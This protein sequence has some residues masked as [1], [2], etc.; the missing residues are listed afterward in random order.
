MKTM[1]NTNFLS[2][3]LLLILSISIIGSC[4]K[5]KEEPGEISVYTS[6]NL[7]VGNIEIF[8]NAEYKGSIANYAYVAST[9]ECGSSVCVNATVPDG[10]FTL[11]AVAD[12]GSEWV[13]SL[14]VS[15]G[16]CQ[17]INL[18]LGSRTK[19]PPP[20]TNNGQ[21][22]FWETNATG[23]PS[24]TDVTINGITNKVT[25]FSVSTPACGSS[26]NA[27]FSLPPGSYNYTASCSGVTKTGTV[28]VTAGQCTPVQ[29]NWTTPPPD[30][31]GQVVFWETS[32]TGCPTLTDVVING[33]T[34]QISTFSAS[35]PQ[36]GSTGNATFSLNAGTYNY[37]ANCSGTSKTGTVSV[38]ANQCTPV[39]LI[40]S[41]GGDGYNCINGNCTY[42]SSN[43]QYG[44]LSACQSLCSGPPPN[45]STITFQNNSYTPM[46]ITF[47][48]TTK[49]ASAGGTAVFTG[50]PNTTGTG[51]AETS[52]VT[53][54]GAQVGS[55]LIWN[56]SYQYPS[57]G[58]NNVT[59]N[60]GSDWFFI[61]MR[62]NGTKP[63]V[64][65]YVN[66]GLNS[67]SYD[68]ITIQN[69]N[70]VTNIG[71]YKAWSNSNVRADLQGTTQYITWNHNNHF[72]LP[73]TQNQAA[74]LLNTALME[75]E[76]SGN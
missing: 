44:S 6:S 1:F 42:T 12:D 68:N 65:F 39:Q 18:T 28:T 26:G 19:V 54:A 27:T 47:S 38:I 9:P 11:K 14:S 71:Y 75:I 15:D 30:G 49:T 34:K 37:S 33:V 74:N 50:T 53:T 5:T 2:I 48:G 66:Y 4:K 69:N 61:K 7:G 63:L 57:S 22:V 32:A 45:S 40:W 41:G 72:T 64:N 51:S 67:Q 21:V 76:V 8:L 29:L 55:K 43:A 73:W 10:S 58:N 25:T 16:D 70:T 36:C 3:S 23:C 52:G 59:L 60:V 13:K 46:T 62:N 17:L 35:T 31:T 20:T 24:A 56:L